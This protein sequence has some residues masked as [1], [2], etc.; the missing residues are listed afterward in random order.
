MAVD[1]PFGLVARGPSGPAPARRTGSVRRTSTIDMRWP[2]GP[3]TQLRLTGRSRDLLTPDDGEL[4]VLAEDAMSVG[5]NSLTRTIEDIA[6]DP[7]RPAVTGMIGA[8]GGGSSRKV[9]AEVLP[10][11]AAAGTPL[12]LMLDDIAGASLVAGFA[13]SRWMPREQL[14]V[15]M[16]NGPRRSMEGIC[17]GFQPG[18]EALM[19]DGSSRWNH[20]VHTVGPLPR[21]DDPIGWHELSEITEIS[22]RRARRIDVTMGDVIEID[23]MFQDSSTVP[24]GGRVAVHEYLVKATA[25]R[26]TGEILSMSAD[27]RVLPYD[28]CPLASL[29]VDRIV[30]TPLRDLRAAVL[31]IF[32][33]T[34]GCTHLNDAM[35][36]MAEV[37]VLVDALRSADR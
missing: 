23:S 13:Y 5:V 29:S 12:Y 33:G 1:I 28:E 36:A 16:A 25:D 20:Q 32:P 21:E 3:G 14:L 19:P 31:E 22:M 4:V 24:E 9:L 2:E 10:D 7:P 30:G 17:T 35:R 37:P 11:E 26:V 15:A 34:A 18:S 6:T 27:P 8:R